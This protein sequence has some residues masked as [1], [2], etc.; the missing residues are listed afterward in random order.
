MHDA[1]QLS[2]SGLPPVT[3]QAFLADRVKF[4]DEFTGFTFWAVVAIVILLVV[5]AV[6]L[7]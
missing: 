2:A 7:V 4:W 1:P 3:E 6:F 5:M